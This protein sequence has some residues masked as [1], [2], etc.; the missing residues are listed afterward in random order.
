MGCTLP[1]SLTSWD[2]SSTAPCGLPSLCGALTGGGEQ[3]SIQ[4]VP[5]KRDQRPRHGQQAEW[6]WAEVQGHR[7]VG[8]LGGVLTPRDQSKRGGWI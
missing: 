4:Q 7:W 3:G 5:R 1:S 2:K 8:V 6:G